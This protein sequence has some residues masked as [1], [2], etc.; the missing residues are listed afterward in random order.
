MSIAGAPGGITTPH[1]LARCTIFNACACSSSALVGMHPQIRHVP[2]SAFC[3]ST[4]ATFRPSCDARIAATYPPVPAPITTTSY[5]GKG[6]YYTRRL[7]MS[8]RR[9]TLLVVDNDEAVR[10][11]LTGFLRRDMRVLRAATGE[12]A[13]QMM[14]KEDVDLM[15]LDAHLPGI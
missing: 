7:H 3:F 2:P 14:E 10:E 4:T 13:L 11:A 15:V 12:G 8:D 9:K 1:S 6:P 5:V